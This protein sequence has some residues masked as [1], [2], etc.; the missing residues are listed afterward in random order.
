VAVP[1][2]QVIHH[3]YV[4]PSLQQEFD[5]VGADVSGTASH[6]DRAWFHQT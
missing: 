1:A 2:R 6:Y 3:G 4:E 5:R